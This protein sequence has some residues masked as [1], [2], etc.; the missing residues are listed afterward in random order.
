MPTTA[1]EAEAETGEC[2]CPVM[3][4][5]RGFFFVRLGTLP[6]CN[7]YMPF[8]LN[9]MVRTVSRG[10]QNYSIVQRYS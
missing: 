3:L 2:L 5:L 6:C 8:R 1:K 9:L 4:L 10:A 7:N